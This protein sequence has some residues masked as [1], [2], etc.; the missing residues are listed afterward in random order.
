LNESSTIKTKIQTNYI[1][2]LFINSNKWKEL[3]YLCDLCS[4]LEKEELNDENKT[5]LKI[6]YNYFIKL[7]TNKLVDDLSFIDFKNKTYNLQNLTSLNKSY[8]AELENNEYVMS[9]L[10]KFMPRIKSSI[11][12]RSRIGREC[13]NILNPYL[14]LNENVDLNEYEKLKI[15][16]YNHYRKILSFLSSYSELEEKNFMRKNINYHLQLS[17]SNKKIM[18]YLM[19]APL[20][21]A[22]LN[23]VAEPV[24]ISSYEKMQPL[25]DWLKE[26]P[27]RLINDSN[28]KFLKGVITTDGRL[29]LC[30]QVI[31][32]DGIKPLLDSIENNK[33]INRL[34]LGNN[35]IGDNGGR[36]IG[37]FIKSGKSPLNVWYI[38]GNNLTA[39]G[40]RPIAE[41][42]GNDKQ[43]TGLWLKRNPLRSDGMI[44]IGKLMQ[45]NKNIQ[46]LDLLNCG[47]LDDGVKILFDSLNE[48]KTLKHIYLSANGITPIGLNYINDYYKNGN[49]SFE[50]LFLGCNRIGNE[51][52]KIISEFLK[53]DSKLERLNLA[54]SRIGAEGMKCLAES[55]KLHPKLSVLDLGYMRATMDLGELGNYIEDEG[56][57]YLAKLLKE[58]TQLLSINITHNH[59]TQKGMQFIVDALKLNNNILYLDYVQYGV[60]YYLILTHLQ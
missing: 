59:I 34:L 53:Y 35:I 22:I 30:K 3:I 33:Q 26:N 4:K 31:G 23:P 24:D 51:G 1:K 55:L 54:S 45:T 8:P 49:S 58:N 44:W 40:I 56:A 50:T 19:S 48:N 46:V 27:S 37:E 60:Y 28:L 15:K 12:K 5:E 36:L 6:F 52:V 10:A 25:Y 13:A 41:A 17:K 20:S 57:Y 29:D 47:L 32:P 18:E 16:S 39:E 42:L 2:I 9:N 43:V 14:N 38:A 21:D 7:F 11:D